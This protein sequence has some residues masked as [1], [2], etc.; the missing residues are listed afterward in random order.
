M[1]SLAARF[2][3]M[4][5]AHTQHHSIIACQTPSSAEVVSRTRN[6]RRNLFWF[7]YTID[8]E[9]SLRTGQP[10]SINDEHCDLTLP[11]GYIEQLYTKQG[12][13]LSS[14]DKLSIPLFPGD[15]RLTMIKS[16]AYS[17]LYSARALQKSDAEL[18]K[19]IR[20]LDDDL[21]RWRISVPPGFRPTISFSHETPTDSGMDMQTVVT[22]LAY[23]HCMATIHEASSR[24]RARADGQSSI[25]EGVS[26]SLKLAVEAS[27]SS[28]LY[29]HT[30]QHVLEDDCFWY[31]VPS[32]YSLLL[33]YLH[34][35][36]GC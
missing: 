9:L 20:E 3:F 1:N 5:G 27:R 11:P 25:M 16:R 34:C 10:P 28:F 21:E 36:Y 30:A 24:C 19:D 23:H 12:Y 8:N 4:L 31:V 33:L 18:L 6:H 15:L 22:R 14:C 13:K 17:S 7:C 26:S 29:L 35:R 2:A 32:I